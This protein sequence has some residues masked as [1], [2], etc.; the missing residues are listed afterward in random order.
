MYR[1]CQIVGVLL[2]D[3]KYLR[4]IDGIMPGETVEELLGELESWVIIEFTVGIILGEI[5]WVVLGKI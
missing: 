3:L 4:L 5:V 1:H 2:G